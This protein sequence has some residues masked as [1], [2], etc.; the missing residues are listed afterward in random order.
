M[1]HRGGG[2]KV[3]TLELACVFALSTSLLLILFVIVALLRG[4]L[5]PAH[6]H[7]VDPATPNEGFEKVLNVMRL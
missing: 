3:C 4:N 1:K 2:E 6:E 7:W 5:Q